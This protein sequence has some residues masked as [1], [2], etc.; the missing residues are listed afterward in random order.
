MKNSS[1]SG[2]GEVILYVRDMGTM[3]HFY[4][5]ILQLSLLHDPGT[6]LAQ[7]HWVPFKAGSIVLALHA[8]RR[9]EETNAAVKL[10]FFTEHLE[11]TAAQL[12]EC[13]VAV[14]EVRSP[15][16]GV[17]VIDFADPEGNQLSLEE[18]TGKH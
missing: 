4:G 3:A 12:Q 8:G 5:E 11:K 13:G 6:S 15:V 17:R 7:E 16:D 14:G 2:V 1:I 10:V 9:P 18:N